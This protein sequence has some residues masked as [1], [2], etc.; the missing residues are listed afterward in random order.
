MSARVRHAAWLVP[1]LLACACAKKG[2]PS[3]GPPDLEPPRIVATTPDS[4]AAGVG[5]GS[6]LSF[7]FSE[8]MEPRST[9]EAIQIAPPVDIRQFRWRGRTVTV[10]LE[11][12]LRRDVTYTLSMANTAR[13]RHGNAMRT[14]RAIAFSTADSFPPGRL[15]G[16]IDARGFEAEGTSLWT[17]RGD[18][19]PDSTA[20]DY[21]ALGVASADGSFAIVGLPVPGRY[22][23]WAFADFNRNRSYEP[24]VD[25]LAAIDTVFDL[26]DARSDADGLVLRV[27]NP[28]APG[29]IQGTVIDSSGAGDTLGVVRVFAMAQDDTTR[30]AFAEA[31]VDGAFTLTL[32]RGPWWVVA[33]R[34]HDRNRV[35]RWD[36]EPGSEIETV[37]VT[38]AS[39]FRMR[40]YLRRNM[41]TPPWVR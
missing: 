4:G 38:P 37:E 17:Y 10:V 6:V 20:R 7:T 8:G 19:A 41:G 11:D 31:D 32:Q 22:R 40:F 12:S 29:V 25:V 24:D 26:S 21:D 3:G 14:G 35:W 5:S 16:T 1:C 33:Y 13:D 30:R 28:H 39:E 2:P 27:T 23:V 18:R 15:A 9:Q 36:V 34:D